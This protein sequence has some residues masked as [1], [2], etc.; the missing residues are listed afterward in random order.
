MRKTFTKW[1]AF[2]LEPLRF[3]HN[4]YHSAYSKLLEKSNMCTL[5]L[6]L[7]HSICTEIFK[8]ISQIGPNYMVSLISHNQQQHSSRQPLNL[9]VPRVNQSTF[10]L[11]SFYYLGLGTLLWNSP[12]ENIKSTTD[13]NTFKRLIKSWYGPTFRCNFCN[14]AND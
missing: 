2:S 5:E 4:D 7:I 12:P 11:K 3:V 13:F 6:R 8:T 14:F 1:K 10:G 9:F